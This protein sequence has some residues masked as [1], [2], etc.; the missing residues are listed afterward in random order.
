M[1]H[2]V[3]LMPTRGLYTDMDSE[4]DTR[5]SAHKPLL[6]VGQVA[7]Q[8]AVTPR[9]VR[10]L[11]EERRIPYCKLGKFVRFHPADVDAWVVDRRIEPLT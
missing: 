1:R 3:P 6:D 8:L 10:R 4:H 2:D 5:D 9:F 11:V 7:I